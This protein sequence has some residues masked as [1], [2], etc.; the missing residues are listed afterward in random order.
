MKRTTF[1]V[2]FFIKKAK[3]VRTGEAPI[4]CRITVN[5]IRT[6]FAVKRS[7]LQDNWDSKRGRVRSGSKAKEINHFLEH[8]RFKLYEGQKV[9]EDSG[10]VVTARNLMS[11]YN[12]NFDEEKCLLEVYKEHNENLEKLIGR[13]FSKL[14]HVRHQTSM[15]HL[16]DFLSV[17]YK[18]NDIPLCEITPK[19]VAD[20]EVY[21]RSNRNCANNTTVK[22][23]KNFKKIVNLALANGWI[24]SNPFIGVRYKLEETGKVFL[25]P[26]ELESI[27]NKNIAI[28]R[29]RYVRDVFLFCCYTGLA[30][31]DVKNL[32]P[33]DLN[34]GVDGRM[35]IKKSRQKTKQIFTLPLLDKPIRIIQEYSENPYC[36]KNN[37]LLPV[38][39]N[40][41]M[42]AYLKEVADLCGITKNLTTHCARHTFATTVTLAKG[43]SMEAV[44]KMLGHSN[45]DMTRHY[46]KRTEELIASE[47]KKIAGD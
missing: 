9:L 39:S 17:K 14:T 3:L 2:L 46:A 34:I 20:Y 38:L 16:K 11:Y 33:N 25:S 8:I 41:K 23:L 35:W 24:K 29:I 42:N 7:V 6:E 12:G 44:S 15:S 31:I 30:F 26:K 22:Y 21:L 13:G 27:E 47:M 40:Q 32:S 43:V 18:M 1:T 5:G 28:D 19:F 45:L 37:V 10:R 4:Y 36:I